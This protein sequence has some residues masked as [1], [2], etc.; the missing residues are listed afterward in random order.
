MVIESDFQ[1]TMPLLLRV[2]CCVSF[3]ALAAGELSAIGAQ[4]SQP[5]AK[6]EDTTD[7]P[8]PPLAETNSEPAADTNSEHM[9][10]TNSGESHAAP[11]SRKDRRPVLQR[12]SPEQKAKVY[13]ALSTVIFLG[14]FMIFMVW[15]GARATRRYI[16]HESVRR[17][18]PP[19]RRGVDEDDWAKKPLVPRVD[20]D[21]VDEQDST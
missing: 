10:D 17:P 4:D 6:V 21:D 13:V 19:L 3:L 7:A 9:S 2:A 16:R 1:M 15:L 12:M 20:T 8:S 14:A 18:T 11:P 5:A